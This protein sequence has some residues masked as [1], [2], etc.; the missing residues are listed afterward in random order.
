[1]AS[2]LSISI[3]Y[4][5]A[6]FTLDETDGVI[7]HERLDKDLG[8]VDKVHRRLIALVS[9][10]RLVGAR[11]EWRSDRRGHVRVRRLVARRVLQRATGA[12]DVAGV[13]AN[14]VVCG[15]CLGC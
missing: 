15:V 3:V 1:M 10:L 8:T 13:I 7:D 5:V 9:Q 11:F 2:K 4:N 12:F 14:D 6:L